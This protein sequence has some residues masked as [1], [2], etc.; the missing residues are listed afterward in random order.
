VPEA[1]LGRDFGPSGI[2]LHF[3]SVAPAD[4]LPPGSRSNG[5]G[6]APVAALEAEGFFAAIKGVCGN[7]PMQPGA[8]GLGGKALQRQQQVLIKAKKTLSFERAKKGAE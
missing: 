3:K 8:M 6:E 7:L 2:H 5:L 1:P 4:R